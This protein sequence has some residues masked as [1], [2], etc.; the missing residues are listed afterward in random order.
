M[1]RRLC[2]VLAVAL[3]VFTAACSS[4]T[5]SSTTA[6]GGSTVA[7]TASSGTCPTTETKK[8]AKTLF[9]TDAALA[10]GAF[11]RYIYTPAKEG[12][13]QK[14]AKGKVTAL[15]KAAAA[16]AFAI[17]R[18]AAAKTNVENDPTLCKALIAPIASFSAAVS[19]LVSKAKS[20]LGTINP[21]DVTSGSG[22]LS[23]LH[24]AAS[25]AGN[26]FT[27]NTSTSA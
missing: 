11:K 23:A 25:Q 20:G 27:D 8:F 3:L 26:A 9:V 21:S 19:G 18:L 5:S 12:K 17:N 1:I 22:A 15:I 10:G 6:S 24:N 2:L 7:A 14:G 4:K 16:G 13:F